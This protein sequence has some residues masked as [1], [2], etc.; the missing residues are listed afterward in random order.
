METR[1]HVDPAQYLVRG[2]EYTGQV[3]SKPVAYVSARFTSP[4]SLYS[5]E[6]YI[7][8]PIQQANRDIVD[9]TYCLC[10]GRIYFNALVSL[11]LFMCAY[12]QMQQ[13]ARPSKNLKDLG[14]T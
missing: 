8:R 1:K 10:F 14:Q 11:S 9:W 12:L 2:V 13:V 4:Q 3:I 7:F 5:L 6:K